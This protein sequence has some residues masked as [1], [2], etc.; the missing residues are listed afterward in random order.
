MKGTYELLFFFFLS[1]SASLVYGVSSS[2]VRRLFLVYLL[3]FFSLLQCISA[4]FSSIMMLV[5]IYFR[6][7]FSTLFFSVLEYAFFPLLEGCSIYCVSWLISS[8]VT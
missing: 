7:F 5:H 2:V 4:L 8:T 6:D 3:F 1:P